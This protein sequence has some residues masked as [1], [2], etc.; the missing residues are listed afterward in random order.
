M[1]SKIKANKPVTISLRY[2][3]QKV[4]AGKAERISAE[5]FLSD[6]DQLTKDA[7]LD[8]FRQRSSL[9]ERLHDHGA[10]ITLNFGKK[11]DL[12]KTTLI[13]LAERYMTNMGFEDQPYVVYQHRDAGH[14]HIHIVASTVRADGS[15]IRLEPEDFRRSHTICRQLEQE[16]ALEKSRKYTPADQFMFEV[17]HARRVVYGEPGLKNAISDVL[18]TVVDHYKY[19]SLDEFNAILKEYNVTAN[20][21]LE[22]SRLHNFEGL[23]YHALD[24]DGNRIGAPIKASQFL[25]KPTLKHLEEKFEQNQ[26]LRESARQSLETNILWAIAGQST[27]WAGFTKSLQKEGIAIVSNK[28]EDGTEQLFFVDHVRKVAFSDESLGPDFLPEA[29]RNR[30]VQEEQL[31]QQQGHRLRLHL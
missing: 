20:P 16:F 22:N 2:N 5:N 29:L 24:P 11:E 10:H 27:T 21:G 6:A 4:T 13:D 12:P 31:T 28:E 25:L 18:N 14:D 23:L 19:T 30:C 3:E 1:F 8:R 15:W 17:D 26:T 9:N 7:I